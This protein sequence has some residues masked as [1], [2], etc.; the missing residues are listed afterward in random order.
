V[1][2]FSFQVFETFGAATLGY[3]LINLVAVTAMRWLERRV[4][5]PGAMA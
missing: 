3:L 2:E 4:R 5:V 1:Q